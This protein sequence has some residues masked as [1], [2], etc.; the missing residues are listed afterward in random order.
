MKRFGVMLDC[1]RNA[2]MN[3]EGVKQYVDYLS[4]FGYNTLMLY[5]EDTYEVS[6]EPFFGYMRG[7]YTKDEL[8]EIDAYCNK[9][10]VELIPCIQTLAHLQAIFRWKEYSPINDVNDI[11][12]AEDERTYVLIENMFK[13]LAECFTSRVAHIGMDE[14]HALGLGKYLDKHG[15]K[16]RFQILKKHLEK[17][18]TIAKKYGF[19]CIMWSDM[20]FRLAN[21]GAYYIEGEVNISEEV[22]SAVP[23]GINLVYW[24]YYKDKKEKFDKMIKGH[25]VL[26][27]D[28]WFAGGAWTWVGFTPNNEPTLRTMYPAMEACHENGVE[29]IIITLWGDDGEECSYFSVLPS[30]FAIKKR[31]DNKP[32]DESAKKEFENIVGVSYD[33]MMTLDIPNEIHIMQDKSYDVFRSCKPFVYNDIFNGY[34]DPYLRR[35]ANS[36]FKKAVEVLKANT[37]D[38]YFKDLFEYET[39]LC[40]FLRIKYD[41]GIKVRKAYKSGDKEKIKKTVNLIKKAEKLLNAFY[42]IF[43]KR[44]Y[45]ENK[46]QGFDVQEIRLGGLMLRLKS[47]RE[48]LSDYLSGKISSIPELEEE[49][50]CPKN[51]KDGHTFAARQFWWTT[52]TVNRLDF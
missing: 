28:M 21:H 40:E 35:D 37:P 26:D 30:L 23:E 11:L 15:Y 29:N 18:M 25:H 4:A 43:R 8:K 45:K 51:K 31:Y 14:A 47:C 33:A 7:R 39:A 6:G 9:K 50:I 10:G 38:N 36:F 12:L 42:E 13:T 24:D 48:R 34:N 52:A 49:L 19:S 2:V 46:P 3:I 16:N 32:L 44:W 41:L 20:F 22:K 1:S 17:V 5:T 27:K